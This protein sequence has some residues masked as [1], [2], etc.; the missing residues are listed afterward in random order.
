MAM[1]VSTLTV[2]VE[3]KGIDSTTTSLGKLEERAGTTE[4]AVTSLMEKMQKSSAYVLAVVESMNQLRAAM[5]GAIQVNAISGASAELKKMHEELAKI[6]SSLGKGVGKGIT[7]NIKE[8]GDNSKEAVKGVESLNQSLA[9]SQNIFQATGKELYHIRNLLGGTM[10]AGA[11]AGAAKATLEF[12]DA[13]TLM[14]AKLKMALGTTEK[15][16]SIQQQLF[17]SAQELRVPLEDMAKLYTRLVPA[18]TEYGYSAQDALSVTR[19]MSAALA[20]SGATAAETSSVLLQFSQA[21]Q[22]GRLNGAEFNA[23]AEGAPVVLRAI[24]KELL[25]SRKELKDMGADGE[26]SVTILTDVMKKMEAQWVE[27]NKNMPITFD[28]AMT[29]LENS[30]KRFLGV[31]TGAKDGV[32]AIANAVSFLAKNLDTIGN[33]LI[34]V[35]AAVATFYAALAIYNTIAAVAIARSTVLAAEVGLVGVAAEGSA[36]GIGILKT[37]MD[38]LAK[39]PV[40]IALSV[41]VGLY[42]LVASSAEKAK[43]PIVE[44]NDAINDTLKLGTAAPAALTKLI[45][46]QQSAIDKANKSIDEWK[47]KKKDSSNYQDIILYNERIKEQQAVVTVATAKQKEFAKALEETNNRLTTKFIDEN[48]QNLRDEIALKQLQINQNEKFSSSRVKQYEA[49][50]QLAKLENGIVEAKKKNAN[51]DVSI[52]QANVDK[53]K[54]MVEELKTLVKVDEAYDKIGKK[55][56]KLASAGESFAKKYDKE[57]EKINLFIA[58]Q[59]EELNARTKLTE[60]Q[61][62]AVKI[63]EF[64]ENN[65]KKLAASEKTRLGLAQDA[66]L[67]KGVEIEL[68]KAEVKTL[69]LLQDRYYKEQDTLLASKEAMRLTNQ[70]MQRKMELLEMTKAG[71]QESAVGEQLYAIRL[72]ESALAAINVTKGIR[73]YSLKLAKLRAET[74]ETPEEQALAQKEIS[75][76]KEKIDALNAQAAALSN[77]IPQQKKQLEVL[78]D[79]AKIT[80]LDIGRSPGQILADGFGEAGKAIS[81]MTTAYTKFGDEATKI[82]K[83]VA[84]KQAALMSQGM[85]KEDARI[86]AEQDVADK[87]VQIAVSTYAD[88]AGAAKGFFS[89]NSKGYQAMA[90][91]EKAFRVIE[92]ALAAKSFIQKMFFTTTETGAAVAG[93]ITKG[94]AETTLTSVSVGESLIRTA[95][96]AK[97]AVVGAFV[98]V[99]PTGFVTGAAMIAILAALGFAM[100]GGGGASPT[101]SADRQAAQGTGTVFGDSS[102]KSE[103]VTKALDIVAD[104]S[105]I[106]LSYNAGMLASLKNIESALVGVAK[107]VV[108]GG[109][110]GQLSSATGMGTTTDSSMNKAFGIGSKS[111]SMNMA[112]LGLGSIINLVGKALFSVKKSVVDSG[113]VQSAQSLTE[114][115][116]SGLAVKGYTDIETKKKKFGKTKTSTETNLSDLSTE[117]QDQ[118]T[119]VV[120]GLG[121]SMSQAAK[122]LK[123]DGDNFTSTLDNFVVD[124]GR[125]S[126]QGMN[127][128]QIQ[129]TLTNVFSKLGDEMAA[130]VMP[131]FIQFQGIG[132]GYMETLIRVASTVAT[133]DGIF[134]EVGTTF[135][136]TGMESVKAKMDL[137]ELAGGI[138][139]L[140]SMVGNFFDKFYTEAEKK[141]VAVTNI[142]TKMADL[143]VQGF[144]PL[145]ENARVV[146]RSMVENA[147]ETNP[148]LMVELLKLSDAVDSVAPA[149]KKA[150]DAAEIAEKALS[151]QDEYNKLTMSSS[152]YLAYAR[153]KELEAM[154]ES[155]RPLQK[156]IYALQD[157]AKIT[158]QKTTLEDTYNK[159]A[160]SGTALLTYNRNLELAKMDE[161]LRPLQMRIYAL[162]DEKAALE[163][164]KTAASTA[165]S[166]LDKSVA[167]QKTNLKK[168]LDIKVGHINDL[169]A[170]ENDRYDAERKILENA[171]SA[172]STYYSKLQEDLSTQVGSVK[173]YRDN[174]KS[175]FDDISAAIDK[176]TQSGVGL[177]SQT[178]ATAKAQLDSA[179]ALASTSGSLPDG[180]KFKGVLEALTS[181]D[182]SSFSSLFDFQREQLVTAGKLST[183]KGVTGGK[184]SAADA[185]VL[186][187]ENH[188]AVAKASAES[189]SAYYAHEL[190][191]LE[192]NHTDTIGKLDEEI[193]LLNK[194]YEDDVFYL[195]GILQNARDQLDIANGTYIATMDVATAVAGFGTA[196]G[197][198][199]A[200]KDAEQARLV[201]QVNSMSKKTTGLDTTTTKQAA[202]MAMLTTEV[203]GLREDLAAQNKAI[204]SNTLTTAKVLSQWDGD[205]QPEVRNVA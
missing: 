31:S 64:I 180:E 109:V 94:T 58:K 171:A 163:G 197:A 188:L 66:I 121:D 204:A 124:I 160:L 12:T 181:L 117:L 142:T 122:A 14:N 45:N 98:G 111:A 23:M 145:A 123:L 139:E 152:E 71:V 22:S 151:Q 89:E 84:D 165:L 154:D 195:D 27:Q 67:T 63:S 73:E 198:Y 20:I 85:G 41:L 62:M 130:A 21:M 28:K 178:Y 143:G 126:I 99:G 29:Q 8:I 168:E 102:A 172:S 103:S 136:T 57:I 107:L 44:A 60:A 30:M 192:E 70:E 50:K 48:I 203:A 135:G 3:S 87:R 128:E 105:E 55:E 125:I 157:E 78:T 132:E 72:N 174:I 32:S 39:H 183:L 93:A 34:A 141:A 49:E 166:V 140:S 35:T 96:K 61:S 170:A 196:L 186:A 129:E 106:S 68:R 110:Q 88:M 133:V 159:L 9:K 17:E 164:L 97:E 201:E 36:L 144:D 156:R 150:A 52:M 146:F 59:D 148:K 187:A 33:T 54:G 120:L 162:Q 65:N 38:L 177:Q 40:I 42:T 80:M 51:A 189:A 11:L 182:E 184:L 108:R 47:A 18:M 90:K 127:A 134:A 26:I 13:W 147:K 173:E 16:N 175:L 138:Q 202:D 86:A 137:V 53:Q 191:M 167:K 4:R 116:A 205:G 118:L 131:G 75:M 5:N 77:L 79:L 185:A 1:D 190:G 92:L 199:V 91:A 15:A 69:E 83:Y 2:K 95:V 193:K 74:A 6:Q 112:T 169:K 200:A 56:K 101:L 119:K 155:L 10:L 114:I 25:V 113:L 37:A 81:E 104:N 24:Q 19:A 100:S 158:E 115:M 46:E 7:I 153:G 179:V 82:N 161:S 194:Q 43:D 176:L 149:F 76:L